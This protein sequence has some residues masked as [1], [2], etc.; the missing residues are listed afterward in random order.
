MSD[1]LVTSGGEGTPTPSPAAP[2][3]PTAAPATAP[4]IPSAPAAPATSGHEGM[5]PSY[6]LREAREAAERQAGERYAQ[7][8]AAAQ[9]KYADIERKF[10]ALAGITPPPDPEI[11]QVRDQFGRLYPGLSKLEENAERL[12]QLAEKTGD[13]EAQN[14]H[15]WQS[16]GRQQVDRL[17]ATAATALGAPLSEEGKRTLHASFTGWVSSSPELTQRYTSD[18]TIVDDFMKMFTS[19]FI[20]PARRAASATVMDRTGQ[21]IPRDTP[22]GVPRATPA[23]AF[24]S[25][26]ERVAAGWKQL[27][28]P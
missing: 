5:V 11:G 3:Q 6:R 27:N 10:N 16:Y 12:L 13:L 21:A 2:A 24:Q 25:L 15:Y 8:E 23:P 7:R 14:S 17:Y 18:P 9:A 22:G 28:Q 4:A 19:S 1:E 20:D 26:D